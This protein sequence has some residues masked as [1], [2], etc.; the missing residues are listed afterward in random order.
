MQKNGSGIKLG[1]LKY[2]KKNHE[3]TVKLGTANVQI[4]CINL[5]PTDI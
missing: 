5:T 2:N 1:Q 3:R 4:F